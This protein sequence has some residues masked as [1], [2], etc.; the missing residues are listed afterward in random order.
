M[1]FKKSPQLPG[2]GRTWAGHHHGSHMPTSTGAILLVKWP[3]NPNILAASVSHELVQNLRW[4]IFLDLEF[5]FWNIPVRGVI[6]IVSSH[7]IMSAVWP[8][9]SF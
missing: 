8:S 7:Q 9:I 5:G 1:R 6:S 2:T 3:V 4:G